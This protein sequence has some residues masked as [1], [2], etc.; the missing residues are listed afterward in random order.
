MKKKEKKKRKVFDDVVEI[1]LVGLGD[2]YHALIYKL[3]ILLEIK[4]LPNQDICK[5]ILTN[6]FTF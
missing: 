1:F 6:H 3:Q 5:R 2:G 4:P